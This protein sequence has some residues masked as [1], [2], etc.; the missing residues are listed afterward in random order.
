MPGR[1]GQRP[2]PLERADRLLQRVPRSGCRRGRSRASP[3]CRGCRRRS[4]RSA[5]AGLSGGTAHPRR[6]AG[7][8]GQRLQMAAGHGTRSLD[9]SSAQSHALRPRGGRLRAIRSVLVTAAPA[10]VRTD[11]S[12][13]TRVAVVFGGTSSEHQVSCLTAAG[14]VG[15]ARPGPVRRGRASASPGPA[16]G[17]SVDPDAIAALQHHRRPAARAGRERRPTRCCCGRSAG[18]ELAVRAAVGAARAGPDRRRHL[19]AA[20]PVRRGRHHPGTVRDDGHPLC[21]RGRAGQCGRHGQALHEAGARR[22]AGVPVGPFVPITPAEWARDKAA[23]LEAVAALSYPLF[24][25]PARGGSSLGISRVDDAGGSGR[26]DRAGPAPRPQDHRRA[27][28][29]RRPRAGV[30]RAGRPRRRAAPGQRGGRD[31]GRPARA[32]ST[33]SRPSTCRTSR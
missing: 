19:P 15:R 20:R 8:H 33:T 29:R 12:A 11:G 10:P 2:A 24:V 6:P 9:R 3:R 22:P 17:C 27:G 14:V 31:P 18:S 16:A 4:T 30:R 13:R 23:C 26:R 28:L 21:R 7:G 5:T 1:E 32:G 25:K